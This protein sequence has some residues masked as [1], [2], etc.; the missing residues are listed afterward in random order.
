MGITGSWNTKSGRIKQGIK[1]IKGSRLA[2]R[3]RANPLRLHPTIVP[4][5]YKNSI[6]PLRHL[7][8]PGAQHVS[9]LSVLSSPETDYRWICLRD[10]VFYVVNCVE[11]GSNTHS[12]FALDTLRD[13]FAFHA[14][15]AEYHLLIITTNATSTIG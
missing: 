12:G 14:I 11:N 2:R 8:L 1:L 5:S 6:A 7:A 13:I 10:L 3:P 4:E 9:N 15:A